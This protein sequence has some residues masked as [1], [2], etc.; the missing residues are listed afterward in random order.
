M[1]SGPSEFI[2]VT[3]M[4]CSYGKISSPHTEI[5]GTE[6]AR[7]RKLYKGFKVRRD[8]RNRAS[9]VNRAHMKR[10]LLRRSHWVDL[11]QGPHTILKQLED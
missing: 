1:P 11:W 8:L 4:K 6:P 9:P 3:G 2:P 10:P 7:P 5:S